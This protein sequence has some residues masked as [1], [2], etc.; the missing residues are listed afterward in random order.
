MGSDGVTDKTFEATLTAQRNRWHGQASAAPDLH[1]AKDQIVDLTRHLVS[2]IKAGEAGNLDLY[3]RTPEGAAKRVWRDYISP[4]KVL[5]LAVHS[6]GVLS[7][8]ENGERYLESDDPLILADLLAERVRLF[9]EILEL[10]SREELTVQEVNERIVAD[11]G[12]SWKTVANT[13]LRMTWLESLGLVEWLGDRKQGATSKGREVSRTWNMVSPDALAFSDDVGAEVVPDAPAEIADLLDELRANPSA[14]SD[15]STYN[16]WVPSPST[17]PNKIEN[18]RVAISAAI[19]PIEKNELL[20]FISDR[21]GLKRSSVESMLPFMRAGGFLQE[22]QRGVF[23]ATGAAKAWL[24]SGSEYNFIRLLHANM[25]F[26]GEQISFSIEKTPRNDLY[27]EGIRYGLNKDKVRWIISFLLDAGLLIETSFTSVQAS[28]TG[29]KFADDLPLAVKPGHI[30]DPASAQSG[31]SNAVGSIEEESTASV[32]FEI[33]D[34]LRRTATDPGADGKA[35]GAAF[36]EFIRDAFAEMGFGARR[37]SGSG[38]TDVLVQ[39]TD[40]SD[41][42]RA[43]IIDGKSTSSGRVAHTNVSDVALDTHKEKNSADYVAI[44][45]PAFSG[46]TIHAMAQKRSWALITADELSRVVIASNKLGLTPAD[47]G[48]LFDPFEGK[49]ALTDL[50]ETKER[51]L[52]IVSLVVSRLRKESEDKEPLSPRDISLIERTSEIGPTVAEVIE[53]FELFERL[54]FGAVR[55]VEESPDARFATYQLGDVR[56]A[57]RRLRAIAEAI[58]AGLTNAP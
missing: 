24:E 4:L 37:I 53:T 43:A 20:G 27:A 12:L 41:E 15:R 46:D 42:P 36:E 26:V 9:A 34:G 33:T 23:V 11:Y 13:R 8:T 17:D 48:L 22:V 38:D 52:D 45:G 35:S 49:S 44:V 56:S 16:I 50:I 7:L 25:R 54:N 21:F 31:E 19:S 40:A 2:Q 29:V 1:C 39:W 57:V 58:E 5:G 14:H 47:V 3:P 6:R 28:A 10:L 30:E 55:S 18:M 32:A 51:D